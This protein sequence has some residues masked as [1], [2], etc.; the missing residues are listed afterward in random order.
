[1]R[2][3][4]QNETYLLNLSLVE[5]LSFNQRNKQTKYSYTGATNE[6]FVKLG[7]HKIDWFN[8]VRSVRKDFK[9]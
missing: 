3:P 7:K 5:E 6:K 8:Q 9:K 1:M 4:S 2:E